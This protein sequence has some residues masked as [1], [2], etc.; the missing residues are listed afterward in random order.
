MAIWAT[1]MWIGWHYRK[2]I[3]W[4]SYLPLLRVFRNRHE[5]YYVMSLICVCVIIS[6]FICTN[7]YR[8]S[9]HTSVRAYYFGETRGSF[10]DVPVMDYHVHNIFLPSFRRFFNEENGVIHKEELL[11]LETMI[12][13]TIFWVEPLEC[14]VNEDLLSVTGQSFK[15]KML[16]FKRKQTGGRFTFLSRHNRDTAVCCICRWVFYAHVCMFV[17]YLRVSWLICRGTNGVCWHCS[18]WSVFFSQDAIC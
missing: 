16:L 3:I 6:M 1:Y 2:S 9:K 10:V 5:Y 4:C 12:C 18:V 14:P 11:V 17:S 8:I 13:F 7:L 15:G